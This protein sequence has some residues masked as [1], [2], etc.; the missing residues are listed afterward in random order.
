MHIYYLVHHAKII[1]L[2]SQFAVV[3]QKIMK[4]FDIDPYCSNYP[5]GLSD[6]PGAPPFEVEGDDAP[7]YV[8]IGKL[9]TIP[10]T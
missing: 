1:S 4:V 5:P 3:S 6:A 10:L 2:V 9:S 8:Y 7:F